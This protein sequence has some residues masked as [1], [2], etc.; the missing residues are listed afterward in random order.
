VLAAAFA[1]RTSGAAP[2]Q[3]R[4]VAL[5]LPAGVSQPVTPFAN[6]GWQYLPAAAFQGERLWVAG[7]RST[8]ET[9]RVLLARSD[10]GRTF[11]QPVVLAAR[12]FGRG[13]LCAPHPPDCAPKQRFVGDYIGAVAGAGKVWIAFVLPVT[14]A[15]SPNRVDVATLTTG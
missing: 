15:T 10:D 6:R 5:A 14:G 11:R 9:T 13:K 7:Y 3:L 2:A 12:R 1:A 8:A 4:V